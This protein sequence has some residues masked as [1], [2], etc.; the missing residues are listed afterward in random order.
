MR[1]LYENGK[2]HRVFVPRFLITLLCN[3]VPL[4]EGGD[5]EVRGLW[6]RLKIIPFEMEFVSNPSKPNQR[7]LDPHLTERAATW[8]PQFM[9]MLMNVYRD[10]LKA[11]RILQVPAKVE[12]KLDEQKEENDPFPSWFTQT[13]VEC[14]TG[15]VHL[16]RIADR[17]TAANLGMRYTARTVKSKLISYS[18]SVKGERDLECGCGNPNI[19][20]IGYEFRK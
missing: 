16:H 11:E 7:R 2:A 20:L 15:R 14:P 5:N 8:G 1:D 4:F 18:I 13:L 3:A 9:L 12:R 6:R 19:C 17:F 10:Y